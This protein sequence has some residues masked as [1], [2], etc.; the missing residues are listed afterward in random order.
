MKSIFFDAT[1]NQNYLIANTIKDSVNN[2][3]N[4]DSCE[5][6]QPL[7]IIPKLYN[8]QDT[9]DSIRNETQSIFAYSN[10]FDLLQSF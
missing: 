10:H 8:Y 3:T 4:Q 9:R 7:F 2:S 6:E 5:I 1:K